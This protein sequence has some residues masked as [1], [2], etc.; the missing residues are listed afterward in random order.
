MIVA[1]F[2][3]R[4]SATQASFESALAKA[5]TRAP[6]AIATAADKAGHP[7]FVAFAAAREFAVIPVTPDQ[8]EQQET[9][10]V[11][12]ASMKA[13]RG[14]SLSEAAAC[15]ALGAG[16]R[17]Q[18]PRVVSDDQRATCAIAEGSRS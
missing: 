9:Q 8:L 10:T 13:G 17:L 4:S 14:A 5:I 15:A 6:D 3:F 7:A 12:N 18:G 11:S 16:A 2:G 1:G